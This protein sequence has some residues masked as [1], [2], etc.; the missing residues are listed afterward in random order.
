M[1]LLNIPA[2]SLESVRVTE[3]SLASLGLEVILR[4]VNPNL[5]GVTLREVPFTVSCQA[6]DQEH[7]LATGNTGTVT[8]SG[9]ESTVLTIPVTVHNAGIIRALTSFVAEGGVEV[10][11]KGT[12][13]LDCIVTC[14]PVPFSKSVLLTTRQLADSLSEAIGQ[15]VK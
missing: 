15:G 13:S 9:N 2:I 10:T 7:Q 1:P 5:F 11:V 6:G 14:R 3:I 4:V 8:I 12:A